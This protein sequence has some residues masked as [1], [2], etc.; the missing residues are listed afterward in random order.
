MAQVGNS[1]YV[2][3]H[4]HN[5]RCWESLEQGIYEDENDR[6]HMAV[7]FFFDLKGV[8]HALLTWYLAGLIR[9]P[10]QIGAVVGMQ[11]ASL[12]EQLQSL[13]SVAPCNPR[14]LHLLIRLHVVR[15]RPSSRPVY[16]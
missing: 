14:T 10:Q 8:F 6:Y 15:A 2:L 4:E 16:M 5:P 9:G 11:L 3:S 7:L 1:D 12:L 13:Y